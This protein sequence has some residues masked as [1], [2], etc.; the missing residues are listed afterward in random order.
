M[1]AEDLD[2]I[3]P[4]EKDLAAQKKEPAQ[5]SPPL[6]YAPYLARDRS[7]RWSV[8]LADA[9][10]G[11]IAVPPFTFTNF[12]K[13]I[14]TSSGEPTNETVTL[15]CQFQAPP[16]PG[17]Y[18]FQMH[19]LSDSYVGMDIKHD[20]TLMVEDASKADEVLEEDEISEP[21]EDS[22][23]GQMA[24]LK[25]QPTRDPDAPKPERRR[26]RP[27]KEESDYESDTE[28]EEDE[29]DESETDTDT[30]TEDES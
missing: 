1:K 16:Q 8:F 22:I 4:D 21:E 11:K 15:R 12:D 25:G 28:G 26:R 10:Q 5:H 17:E 7:P 6:A 13:P 2:D 3:D 30:D 29:Q 20:I 24:A 23:A 27:A 14:T 19:L 18:K 9:R